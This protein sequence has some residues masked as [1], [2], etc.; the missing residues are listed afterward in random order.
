MTAITVLY[1]LLHIAAVRLAPN[2]VADGGTPGTASVM[3]PMS[4]ERSSEGHTENSA[5]VA[6]TEDVD[7]SGKHI[8]VCYAHFE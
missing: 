7:I 3:S 8:N 1:I 2:N 5:G 6:S 4:R